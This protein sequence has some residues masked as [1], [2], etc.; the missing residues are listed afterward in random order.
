MVDLLKKVLSLH[1]L[2][3]TTTERQQQRETANLRY[4]TYTQPQSYAFF[5][6]FPNLTNNKFEK[7]M[8][9]TKDQVKRMLPGQTLSVHCKDTPEL[10]STYQVALQAR[11]EMPDFDVA[12]S[13]SGKTM[14]VGI[15]VDEKR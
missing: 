1:C 11:K 15:K 10:D 9:L 5:F 2:L 13:R 6:V 3:K 7:Q 8:K 14:I 4:L 12:I